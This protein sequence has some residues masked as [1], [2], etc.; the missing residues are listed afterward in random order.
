MWRVYRP[1]TR[2]MAEVKKHLRMLLISAQM[3][4]EWFDSNRA[5]STASSQEEQGVVGNSTQL[6]VLP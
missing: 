1:G 4:S 2:A 5:C 6:P 3:S